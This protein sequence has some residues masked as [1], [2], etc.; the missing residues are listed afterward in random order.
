VVYCGYMSEFGENGEVKYPADIV[1]GAHLVKH[2]ERQAE[3]FAENKKIEILDSTHPFEDRVNSLF[4]PYLEAMS[5]QLP[6]IVKVYHLEG[7]DSHTELSGLF[8]GVVYDFF[9]PEQSRFI[10]PTTAEYFLWSEGQDGQKI[11]KYPTF[12]PDSEEFMGVEEMRKRGRIKKIGFQYNSDKESNETDKKYTTEENV[13]FIKKLE[14]AL[15][16]GIENENITRLR[17]QYY[18]ATNDYKE[19]YNQALLDAVP[20]IQQ[21][22]AHLRDVIE[23]RFGEKNLPEIILIG[24]YSRHGEF[25]VFNKKTCEFY[26]VTEKKDI[27]KRIKPDYSKKRAASPEEW[28]EEAKWIAGFMVERSKGP[29]NK[30]LSSVISDI[31]YPKH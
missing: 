14:E 11:K 6:E 2:A 8:Q 28:I 17:E 27:F 22:I 15:P 13:E 26:F 31:I 7:I 24:D 10:L 4:F 29:G 5:S 30:Q 21:K 23:D 12:N 18:Q 19:A 16:E 25:R 1:E 3:D 9:R 20:Q